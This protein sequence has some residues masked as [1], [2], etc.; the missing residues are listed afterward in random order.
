MFYGETILKRKKKEK[1]DGPSKLPKS[2]ICINLTHCRY[3]IVKDV[4][5]ELGWKTFHN[6]EFNSNCDVFWYDF[7]TS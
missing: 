1:E 4:C 3:K 5:H 6:D 2:Q 7:A